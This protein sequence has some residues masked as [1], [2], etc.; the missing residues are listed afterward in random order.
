MQTIILTAGR[1]TRMRPLS[2]TMPKPMLPLADKP[3]AAHVA[4]TAVAAGAEKL[5]FTVGYRSD[6]VE[7]FFGAEH[8][9]VPVEY[10][11]QKDQVG[12]ADAVSAAIEHVDG[13]FTVLNG[14][15]V[16]D[17]QSLSNLFQHVPS[18]GFTRVETPEEYGVLTMD[19]DVVTDIVEKPNR[20]ASNVVNTGAYAFPES[21]RDHL[22][23]PASE[24]GEHEL[25]DVLQRVLGDYTVTGI[26][27]EKWA[28]IGHPWELLE[29]TERTLSTQ[30][31][32]VEG[33]VHADA[34]LRGNV[35]VESGAA[36]DSGVVAE[37]PI[38]VRSGATIGPNAYVRGST[39]IGKGASVGHAVEIKNSLLMVDANVNHL[40]YVGDSVLGSGSNLGAGTVTANLRHDGEPVH[41][42]DED[43][44]TS[45][46]KFGVVVGPGAKTGINTSLTPGV[47]LSSDSWT[48]AGAVVT[49]DR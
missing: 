20:P 25:T 42:G 49:S 16:Y 9:G 26:E 12:T 21:V 37:G 24:R 40:S 19:G 1:G 36:I 34:I 46:R 17:E 38:L 43:R 3:I 8:R 47:I 31:R 35:V 29:A 22:D 7:A 4:D 11:V 45:R 10:A 2:D 32:R 13:P 6:V 30:E 33:D 14:D 18:V 5:V 23:V 44:P 27:F 39:V 48:E 41:A 28:D 15:N